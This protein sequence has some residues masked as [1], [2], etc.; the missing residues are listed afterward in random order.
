MVVVGGFGDFG[1][2]KEKYSTE[3]HILGVDSAWTAGQALPRRL[4]HMA[5]VSMDQAVIIL[6]KNINIIIIHSII[7]GW[8]EGDQDRSEVL[9]Y[10]GVEWTQLG[11][12]G[13]A[14][15]F[16]AATKILVDPAVCG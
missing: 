16:S 6:G 2:L 9:S 1:R 4:N 7:G 15:S 14:R 3:K 5:S 8:D 10:N 11:Q 12:M 13:S